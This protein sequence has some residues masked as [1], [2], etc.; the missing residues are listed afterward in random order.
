MSQWNDA[1]AWRGRVSILSSQCAALLG[2][3]VGQSSSYALPDGGTARFR[4]VAIKYQP[5]K[6]GDLHL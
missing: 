6:E 1:D 3:K 2:M 5:E 4:E